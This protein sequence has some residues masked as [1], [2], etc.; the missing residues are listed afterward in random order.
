MPAARTIDR[1]PLRA[2][3]ALLLAVFLILPVHA[4]E[5]TDKLLDELFVQLHDATDAA[6]A[7]TVSNRIWAV[8]TT[9]SDPVLAGR[10]RDIMEA[11][12]LLD[13]ASGI[14]LLDQL[15]LDYPTYAEAWNQRATL[16]FMMGDYEA[17]I[18]DCAKV[19]ELE[20]RHFG[21]LSGRA[22]MYLQQGKRSLAL[23]DM[24]AALELHPFLSERQLF[25][26]LQQ[27]VTRT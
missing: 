10:M 1:S 6:A 9:P 19:L 27:Q 5:A 4:D 16:R 26:E 20:P 17:S 7:R 3:V 21:A 8:W 15:I 2:L 11:R 18:A 12:A 24:K 13:F 23:R 25:P 22:L 14:Q